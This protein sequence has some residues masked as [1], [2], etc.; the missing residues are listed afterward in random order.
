MQSS[1]F[2]TAASTMSYPP[3]GTAYPPPGQE[4]YPPPVY[5]APPPVAASYQQ[6]Q[7]PPPEP[8]DS[9]DG[10]WKGWYGHSIV[11]ITHCFSVLISSN[12]TWSVFICSCAAICCCCLLDMCL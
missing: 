2:S 9:G 5:G 6:Q 8:E 10:F 3:P 12:L 1:Y 7:A 11:K 4:A